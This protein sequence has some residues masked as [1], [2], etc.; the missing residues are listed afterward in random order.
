MEESFGTSQ[1]KAPE[2]LWSNISSSASMTD[3]EFKVKESFD[4]VSKTAPEGS[5]VA[6]NR[7]L[8]IDDVWNGIAGN[9]RRRRVIF[10]WSRAGM[11]AFLLFLVG[12][13]MFNLGLFTDKQ[14]AQSMVCDGGK[15]FYSLSPVS[16]QDGFADNRSV[17][18]ES[19]QD[20][21]ANEE[22]Y[23]SDFDE[24]FIFENDNASNLST[25]LVTEFEGR[26][27][28]QA[29]QE[30]SSMITAESVASSAHSPDVE[31]A[32]SNS[33][34]A[35]NVNNNSEVEDL[36][37]LDLSEIA[38][39]EI[40]IVHPATGYPVEFEKSE[41][42]KPYFELGVQASLGSSWIINNDVRSGFR[43]N[44]LIQNKLSIGYNIGADLAFHF[45]PKSEIWLN[46]GFVSVTKQN[47]SFYDEGRVQERNLKLGY[48]KIALGYGFNLP[49]SLNG[50]STQIKFGVYGGLLFKDI[51]TI[52]DDTDIGMHDQLDFG[53]RLRVGKTY[54]VNRIALRFGLQ[55]DIGLRNIASDNQILPKKFNRTSTLN[56]G[57]Y[58]GLRF[59]L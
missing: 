14:T 6:I 31:S 45:S 3:S 55:S 15:N 41:E 57:P 49:N 10:W 19:D 58:I 25:T 5:W 24:E 34:D 1:R 43:T 7:Q 11:I 12:L 36:G 33:L 42:F 27:N 52:S 2:G 26:E 23:R 39:I 21:L 8:I 9:L 59:K 40:A 35:D 44:S 17:P 51:S 46:Y 32:P 50:N 22:V 28:Q 56:V 48:Q 30:V 37:L 54:R 47:Y 4:A 13:T 18:T 53:I 16:T 20:Q 38:P 29:T